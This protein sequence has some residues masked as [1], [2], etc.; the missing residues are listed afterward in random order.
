MQITKSFHTFFP[1]ILGYS[2]IF[3]RVI[4]LISKVFANRPRVWGSIPSR[5]IPRTQKM[6]LDA[7]LLNTLHYKVKIM[8]KVE[9]S[10]EWS[11]ALPYTLAW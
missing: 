6:V 4:G 9:Q 8:G 10:R 7:T 3:N 5:V 2:I 11:S 1:T